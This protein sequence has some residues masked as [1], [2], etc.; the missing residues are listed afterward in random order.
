[1]FAFGGFNDCLMKSAEVYDVVQN[2]WKRLPDM[3][4]AE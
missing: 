2:S 3:P 1:M 4:D